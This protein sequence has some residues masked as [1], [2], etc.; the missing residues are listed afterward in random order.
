MR[1]LLEI[2]QLVVKNAARLFDRDPNLVKGLF[3][4]SERLKVREVEVKDFAGRRAAVLLPL[5]KVADKR[6]ETAVD[7]T[8]LREAANESRE[9]TPVGEQIVDEGEYVV[10]EVDGQLPRVL[11]AERLLV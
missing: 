11:Q 5:K 6:L 7:A 2:G 4:V 8:E 1:K 10:S 3:S 9:K